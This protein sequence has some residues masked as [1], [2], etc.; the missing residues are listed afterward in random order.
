MRLKELRGLPVVDPTAARKIGTVTDYLV[1]PAAGRL[2]ALEITTKDGM[3][4]DRIPTHR[5]RRVGRHAVV[6]TARATSS[7]SLATDPE[8]LLDTSSLVGLEVLGDDGNRIGRLVDARFNQD[9][10]S[11][12]AYLMRTSFWQRLT[13]RRGR[14]TPAKVHACSRE[15]MI[16]TTG[17][18]KELPPAED[19]SL[20]LGVPLKMEDRLPEPVPSGDGQAVGARSE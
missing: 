18:I 2:A 13:A 10:L 4:P 20:S 15:L 5:V 19:T 6:L 14:I 3:E 9:T 12:E 7:T 17:R 16:V 8:R 1:D 11:I